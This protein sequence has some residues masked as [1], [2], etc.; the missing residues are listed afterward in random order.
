VDADRRDADDAL[1]TT[2]QQADCSREPEMAY[3]EMEFPGDMEDTEARSGRNLSDLERWLS[4]AAGS[5]LALY[6]FSRRRPAG[7]ALAAL[8][9]ALIERGATGRCRVYEA[10]GMNTAGTADDTRRA[11][12]GGAGTIVEERVTIN[13]PIEELY[14]F[15]RNLE[16]LPRFMRHLESVERVTDTLSR[17]RAKGP[18]G[19]TLEWNAEIINEVPNKVIG[20]RSL[21]GSDVTSAGSVNF[22]EAPDRGTHVRVRLQYS[23]P[24]GRIGAAL[25]WLVGQDA[26]TEIREDLHRFKQKIES[27]E[28]PA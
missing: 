17:W 2:L 5:G 28:V 11:L 26:A 1:N 19:T 21:E 25:A 9:G 10:F 23:P 3:V 13:R 4:L 15:W 12:G 6:G 22:D 16:N 27:G 7:F 24:G 8:G 18:A 20:W 14:R